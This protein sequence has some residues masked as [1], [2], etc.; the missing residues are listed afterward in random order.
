MGLLVGLSLAV[1][2]SGCGGTTVGESTS[3]QETRTSTAGQNENLRYQAVLEPM[4]S[5]V[6][7]GKPIPFSIKV[8]ENGQPV[9]GA[10]VEVHFEMKEMDHGD[11]AVK[12]EEETPGEYSGLMNLPM[13]GAWQAYIRVNK[14]D[15]QETTVIDL[16]AVSDEIST[17]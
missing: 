4:R 13:A 9:T 6:S 17:H 7:M 2:L 16:A 1:I 3:Q 12:A 8:S 5:P 10:G 15:V 11:L 14:G